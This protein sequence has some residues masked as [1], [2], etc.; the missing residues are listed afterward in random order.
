MADITINGV[1]VRKLEYAG[2]MLKSDEMVLYIDPSGLGNEKIPEE[3]MADLI[4][5]THEHFGH[6]DPDSIRKIRKSDCTTL[7]PEKISLQFRADARRVMEG[8]SLTGELSIKGVD[9]EVLP[10]YVSC[11][12]GRSLDEGVGYFFC[13][14]GLNIYHA[15]HSCDIADM[16]GLSPDVIMLTV[17]DEQ[18]YSIDKAV[19]ILTKLSPDYVIPMCYDGAKDIETS[20]FVKSIKSKL[21]TTEVLLI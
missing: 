3:D 1:L 15:G 18:L 4:L 14:G 11:E 12:S 6:C 13:F 21:P 19:D 9:I 10:S 2:F 16:E 17:G 5:I 7:I 20:E 8:D